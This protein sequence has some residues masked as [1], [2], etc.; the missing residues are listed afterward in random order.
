MI[1]STL[2]LVGKNYEDETYVSMAN[3]CTLC[4]RM[5]LNAGIKTII[6]R[7]NEE[8][9]RIIDVSTYIEQD[10]SLEITSGY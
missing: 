5:I 4:K 6:I 7:D 2:Y 1:D 10:D 9:Y 3:P 8:S